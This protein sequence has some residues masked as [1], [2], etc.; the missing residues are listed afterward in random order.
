LLA[1]GVGSRCSE[2]RP[3]AVIALD[4]NFVDWIDFW[5]GSIGSDGGVEMTYCHMF[6][7]SSQ[8]WALLSNMMDR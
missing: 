7:C 2:D 6:L 4:I 3:R 8:T 5:R 1:C